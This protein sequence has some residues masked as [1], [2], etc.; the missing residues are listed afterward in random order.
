MGG[1]PGVPASL[2]EIEAWTSQAL[3]RGAV[4]AK[5]A[6]H[7][8][9]FAT[10]AADG[11]PKLR[12]V[13]LRRF[14]PGTYGLTF[15]TDRRTSK[16]AELTADA[17]AAVHLYDPKARVQLRFSGHAEV[18]TEGPVWQEALAR[19]QEGPLLDYTIAPSPGTPIAAPE[20]AQADAVAAEETF[21]VI[22]FTPQTADYLRL[23]REGHRRARLDFSVDPMGATW[24]VP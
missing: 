20:D 10:V 21:A 1:E 24:L 2:P 9:T 7:W 3:T 13:V 5:H 15:T 6:F 14:D 18:L 23:S 4:D 22:A 11:A 12:T 17:R 16:V 19:A 8:P